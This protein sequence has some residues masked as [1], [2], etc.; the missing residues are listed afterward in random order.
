MDLIEM[1]KG[2]WQLGQNG[3]GIAAVHRAAIVPFER[4]HE[5]LRH[6][7]GLGASHR[8]MDR[9]EPYCARQGMRFVGPV[10]AAVI[11]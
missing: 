8:G 1:R 7:V 10:G 2:V 6:A 5:A 9:F 11:A 3:L 4:V